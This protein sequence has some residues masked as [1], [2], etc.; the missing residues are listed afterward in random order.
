VRIGVGFGI[1]PFRVSQTLFRTRSRRRHRKVTHRRPGQHSGWWWTG[2]IL[3][4]MCAYPFLGAF[5]I[6]R[7]A[8]RRHQAQQAAIAAHRPAPLPQQPAPAVP[9]YAQQPPMPA[10]APYYP[11]QPVPPAPPAAWV[12]PQQPPA[13]PGA[14]GTGGTVDI[15]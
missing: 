4:W 14:Y 9:F 11:Q 12:P 8:W 2:V 6:G 1:G 7:W 13:A 3:A 15:G 10:P 5:Y